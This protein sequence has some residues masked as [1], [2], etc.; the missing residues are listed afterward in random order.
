MF[1]TQ[2][3]FRCPNHECRHHQDPQ[4]NWFTNKRSYRLKWSGQYVRRYRCKTCGATFSAATFKDTYRQHKPYL[5]KQ[6]FKCY[7]N[8]TSQRQIAEICSTT[9][10]T[11]VRKFRYLAD[12]ARQVHAV[13]ILSG[14]LKTTE[15]QFDEQ[16]TFL[17]S[18]KL[19][20]SIAIAVDGRRRKLKNGG[21]KI[22]D[23]NVG[24]M[25]AK[26]RN[27]KASQE[28]YGFQPDQRAYT[29]QTVLNNVKIATGGKVEI[30]TDAKPQYRSYVVKILCKATHV[31]FNRSADEKERYSR[32]DKHPLWYVNQACA[33]NRHDVSRLRRKT[34][35]TTKE[36]H[37]LRRHLWLYVAHRNGYERDLLDPLFTMTK[38]SGR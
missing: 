35:V 30:T 37:E 38:F 12:K 3:H 24:T 1:H 27:A 11:V 6:V 2:D 29:C 10:K 32:S 34:C 33:A 23:I 21:G 17:R 9:R 8:S 16:E 4:G 13:E 5:N 18:K 7:S 14:N 28:Q 31:T 15:V 19:P 36:V 26:S 25:P 22:I 20:L